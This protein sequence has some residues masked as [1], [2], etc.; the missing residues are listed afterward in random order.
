MNSLDGLLVLQI[1]V[2]V[3]VAGPRAVVV[4]VVRVRFQRIENLEE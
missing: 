3:V 2:D 1:V 4:V